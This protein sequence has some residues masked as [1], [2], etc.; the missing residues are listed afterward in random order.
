MAAA[1]RF[2]Q[3]PGGLEKKTERVVVTGTFEPVPVEES[4]RAVRAMPVGLVER[5]LSAN[6]FDLLR[7]D[8]SLDLR[9]RGVAGVQT[10]LSIRGGTFGQTL[11]LLNGLRLNDVQ[12]GHHHMNLPVPM[13]AVSSI[14]ILRGA[15][16]AYY[17]SDAVGGVVNLIT[18]RPEG[19]EVRLR[20]SVGN[21]GVNQQSGALIYAGSR[22]TEQLTFS[23]DFSTGFM[24]NR[25]FRNLSLASSSWTRTRLGAT[26]ILLA[27]NDRPFG[28]E[29]FYGN[30]NSWE[31]TKAWFASA[32]QELGART[33][34]A[35]GFRR[36]T[37]LFVL[38]RD[39][40][41]VFTNRHAT[42]TYQLAVR[43][44]EPLRRGTAAFNWGV[45]G[46]RDGIVSNNLGTHSR[47]RGA[48]Y[49]ALDF[50]VLR[51]F[52]LTI[53]GREERYT[54]GQRQFSPTLA[55]GAWLTAQ[56]KVRGSLSRA[57]RLPTYTDLYYRDPANRGNPDL[58][59]ESAW[60]YEGGV[61][62]N[63]N[64]RWRLEATYF[65]RRERDGIDYVRRSVNE[66][67]QAQNF[68]RLRFRGVESAVVW[69]MRE[70]QTIDFRYTALAGARTALSGG[71]LSRYAFNYPAH[72]GVAGWQGEWK[73]RL[74]LRTRIG[75]LER[76]G[77]SPYA[78]WD[79]YAARVR[80]RWHPFVQ[81]T[82]ITAT[83]YQE[84]AGV[85]MP[86]RGIIGGVE[87]RIT[88]R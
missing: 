50:R 77:R 2:A 18:T 10:D 32:R 83:Q 43:R 38:Y 39:R 60:M 24:P 71:L 67:W 46:Y 81:L 37:D 49:A 23:R 34:V 62:W 65:E 73:G 84:I 76:L 68:Q 20:S 8:P 85:A 15:G 16:S 14:E 63:P 61:D 1:L 55:G 51:R 45:E 12:S 13:E 29:Q 36:H 88:A 79:V 64:R 47:D 75:A 40:P 7:L 56:I 11:V 42:E 25:D 57:Y 74:A 66:V 69:R 80:G 30:F 3:S 87:W 72:S 33:E 5:L 21:F 52:S 28:A 19:S 78:L 31:R 9:A 58:R 41:Q 17:G 48:A 26:S 22:W 86:G 82:N 53:A 59:P 35:F 27:H 4:D 44:R 54:G 6:V 70:G